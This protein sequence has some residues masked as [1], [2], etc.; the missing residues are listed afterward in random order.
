MLV[1]W[2][3]TL[4]KKSKKQTLYPYNGTIMST[5]VYNNTCGYCAYSKVFREQCSKSACKEV[6]KCVVY[7]QKPCYDGM[8]VNAYWKPTTMYN[9]CTMK[10]FSGVESYTSALRQ[11]HEQWVINSSVDF[12]AN[13]VNMSVC[14]SNTAF[15]KS[16]H[17]FICILLLFITLLLSM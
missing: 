6:R 14:F 7:K 12:F 15:K 13:N 5:H 17:F 2:L 9:R 8:V 16:L 3:S 4:A 11:L 10:V 1:C